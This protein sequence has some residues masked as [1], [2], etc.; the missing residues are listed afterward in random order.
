M[1][2]CRRSTDLFHSDPTDSNSYCLTDKMF[3][4]KS[5]FDEKR[6]LRED[7]RRPGLVRLGGGSSGG[8]SLEHAVPSPRAVNQ[9][10][11]E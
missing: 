5:I 3:N 7:S 11:V 10:Q 9:N 8:M 6:V 2:A 4:L 1:L